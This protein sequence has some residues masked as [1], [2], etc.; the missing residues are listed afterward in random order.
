MSSAM[1][2]GAAQSQSPDISSTLSRDDNATHT[3]RTERRRGQ[4]GGGN[5][6]QNVKLEGA[7][8]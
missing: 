2:Q 6:E 4:K 5:K 7:G 8:E 3:Q 1:S